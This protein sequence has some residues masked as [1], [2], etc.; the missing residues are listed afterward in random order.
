M[1]CKRVT[2]VGKFFLFLT[3]LGNFES[4]SN[5]HVVNAL[6]FLLKKLWIQDQFFASIGSNSQMAM[7]SS[8]EMENRTIV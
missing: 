6:S 2:G 7:I 8:S 1:K 5:C 3:T 4:T